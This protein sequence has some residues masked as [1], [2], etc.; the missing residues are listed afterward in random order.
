MNFA[1]IT[2]YN[3]FHNGHKFQIDFA[4]ENLGCQNLII[5]QSGN[6]VQRGDVAISSKFTRTKM[7]LMSGADIVLEIPQVFA[8]ASAM[9]FAKGSVSI[10]DRLNF[11]DR[12][13]F[14]SENTPAHTLDHVSQIL[15]DEPLEYKN[16]LKANLSLGYSFPK[17]RAIALEQYGY[18]DII[19]TPNNILGIEYIKALKELNSMIFPITINRTN[20]FHDESISSNIASAT[21]IRKNIDNLDLIQ[22]TI[23]AN[24]FDILSKDISVNKYNIDNLSS[25]FHHIFYSTE[26]KLLLEIADMNEHI[27]NRFSQILKEHFLISD[28]SEKMTTKNLTRTRINRIIINTILNNK[29]S[30]LDY[31]TNN[32][33]PYVR[34]LGFKKDKQ[35]LLKDLIEKSDIKI[36]TN[37]KNADK[38]LTKQELSLLQKEINTTNYF[39]LSNSNKNI[40]I[41]A[42]NFENQLVIL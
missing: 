1:I 36:I 7:A 3:P 25:I 35:N 9:Y 21:A 38:I 28:I 15:I 42:N 17:S 2:E 31:F 39:L 23:P 14:G 24:V 34:L 29:Q 33:F 4:K 20:N 40:S 32:G 26:K 30:D 12:L 11:I 5:I 19:S 37:L 13:C 18:K 27:Y 22:N 6:F 10:L 16:L 8:T 41:N